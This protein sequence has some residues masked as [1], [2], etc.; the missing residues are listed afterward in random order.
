MFVKGKIEQNFAL[1]TVEIKLAIFVEVV[2]DV[3]RCDCNFGPLAMNMKNIR[4][5]ILEPVPKGFFFDDPWQVVF[6]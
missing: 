2:E 5:I 3:F 4:H 1:F 6:V